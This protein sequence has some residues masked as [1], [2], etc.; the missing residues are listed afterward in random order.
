M[1]RH[2]KNINQSF[3]CYEPTLNKNFHNFNNLNESI[4]MIEDKQN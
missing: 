1:K 4:S 2:V 3:E